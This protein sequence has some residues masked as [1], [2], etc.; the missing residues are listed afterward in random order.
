MPPRTAPSVAALVLAKA[1]DATAETANSNVKE[2]AAKCRITQ[3][4]LH[5]Y[6]CDATFF[7]ANISSRLRWRGDEVITAAADWQQEEFVSEGNS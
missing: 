6:L 2:P 5:N 4:Q 3:K 1:S 7:R